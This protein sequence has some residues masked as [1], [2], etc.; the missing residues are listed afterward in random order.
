MEVLSL[1]DQKK[2]L[3]Y[4]PKDLLCLI[5]AEDKAW[6]RLFKVIPEDYFID[7]V[8][9]L[10]SLGISQQDDSVIMSH[11]EVYVRDKVQTGHLQ[12][13]LS[14]VWNPKDLDDST[15]WLKAHGFLRRPS[16]PLNLQAS[17]LATPLYSS[18]VA[19]KFYGKESPSIEVYPE[20]ASYRGKKFWRK[21]MRNTKVRSI[22]KGKVTVE[23]E[24][25]Y[26]VSLWSKAC[27]S[28]GVDPYEPEGP[29]ETLSM[30]T[31]MERI[32][33]LLGN[34][35][36][37]SPSLQKARDLW[38]TLYSEGFDIKKRSEET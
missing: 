26:V 36:E 16:L 11:A 19:N 29:G 14:S 9:G 3:L 24:W 10:R 25:D 27:Y 35:T 6:V 21:I 23:D 5:L 17:P 30:T 4:A 20:N 28:K 31:C 32:V 2:A 1:E 7:F 13:A 37:M 12:S 38:D 22:L 15:S 34:S 18:H 8:E 33:S